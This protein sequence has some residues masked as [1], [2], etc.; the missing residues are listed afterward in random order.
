VLNQPPIMSLAQ[1][2]GHT[3]EHATPTMERT[4]AAILSTFQAMWTTFV[5]EKGSFD[6]FMDQYLERW[7]HS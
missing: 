7:L 6:G 3:D 2:L 4:A 5:A 1:L